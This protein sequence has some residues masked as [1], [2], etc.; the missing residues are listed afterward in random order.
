[1]NE[2]TSLGELHT[3]FDGWAGYGFKPISLVGKIPKRKNWRQHDPAA[4]RAAL[5]E[6][7]NIG[8]LGGTPLNGGVMCFGDLDFD[9]SAAYD[10]AVH[11]PSLKGRPQ[12]LT[13]K[14]GRG[15]VPFPVP[16]GTRYSKLIWKRESDDREITMELRS[17]GGHQTVVA[18]IHPE[19]KQL[20][21]WRQWS[22]PNT[23]TVVEPLTLHREISAAL[24]PLGWQPKH[25]F[26]A[27]GLKPKP[28]QQQLVIRENFVVDTTP[29]SEH[30]AKVLCDGIVASKAYARG[31]VAREPWLAIVRNLLQ[32]GVPDHIAWDTWDKVY[33]GDNKT[34]DDAEAARW[35]LG[36]GPIGPGS[37][38]AHCKD[39]LQGAARE[40]IAKL[41]SEYQQKIADAAFRREVNARALD[42]RAH[43]RLSTYA[44]PQIAWR[45]QNMLPCVGTGFVFASHYT[46]KTA[47]VVD[48]VAAMT[49][50]QGQM[51]AG[52][53][54]KPL[55]SRETVL[56]V[57]FEGHLGLKGRVMS[58]ARHRG[59]D[60]SPNIHMITPD[61]GRGA[62]QD[63]RVELETARQLGEPC[64]FVM[65]DTWS[66]ARF[67]LDDNNANEVATVLAE[68][69]KIA[70]NYTTCIAFL[71][72]IT[73]NTETGKSA[74][75]GSGVK[76]ANT[77][78]GYALDGGKLVFEK[79]KDAERPREVRFETAS[80]HGC[81]VIKWAGALLG[82]VPVVQS[83]RR[84]GESNVDDIKLNMS[85]Y[86][87][88]VGLE[89]AWEALNAG[90]FIRC[91]PANHAQFLTD[92]KIAD[93]VIIS[94]SMIC[95]LGTFNDGLTNMLGE[96]KNE[97]TNRMR[98]NR[99]EDNGH[100]ASV[101]GGR[102]KRTPLILMRGD[103]W[104]P[105]F[106]WQ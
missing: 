63:I 101:G 78:F 67:T 69:N 97:S 71:D 28:T 37:L 106:P 29:M 49:C 54:V 80:V 9:D 66:A 68:F 31:N 34:S 27:E 95:T 20:I 17:T 88:A 2:R 5:A 6:G 26:S 73:K 91:V 103:D 62:I 58:A 46:G 100:I 44:P 43:T 13:G 92:Y 79:V 81:V 50:V 41:A 30:D 38:I 53:T 65:V 55:A 76:L 57:A 22:E 47:L 102:S 84:I 75:R 96:G 98:I 82:E 85:S 45:I 14:A 83:R 59:G 48:L 77:S 52:R 15:A 32:L 7:D 89:D 64:A 23:W 19:T 86:A 10:A 72:H 105:R 61:S 33:A 11:V 94:I 8:L 21:Q 104:L 12:R 39:R 74:P 16:A 90:K 3:W 42:R 35:V 40:I 60:I 18:G 24:V 4:E 1:M 93:D 51:W 87:R 99:L 25:A 36:G 56:I 70:T